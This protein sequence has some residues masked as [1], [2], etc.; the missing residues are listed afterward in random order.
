MLHQLLCFRHVQDC[1]SENVASP[2]QEDH[3]GGPEVLIASTG[4][5]RDEDSREL[6][7]IAAE[8]PY[9]H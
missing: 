9:D 3:D 7:S 1:A 4:A 5:K 8:V 2:G 6:G